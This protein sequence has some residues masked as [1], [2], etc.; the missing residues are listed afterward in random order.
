MDLQQMDGL[1]FDMGA[2]EINYCKRPLFD[3]PYG[4]W[5]TRLLLQ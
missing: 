2:D 4:K 1:R 3:P 5:G